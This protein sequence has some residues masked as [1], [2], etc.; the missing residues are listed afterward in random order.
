MESQFM[1]IIVEI[2]KL[3]QVIIPAIRI[4]DQQINSVTKLEIESRKPN[5][6]ETF[7]E[8]DLFDFFCQMIVLHKLTLTKCHFPLKCGAQYC[9]ENNF[10]KY[11]RPDCRRRP[12][13]AIRSKVFEKNW[14]NHCDLSL[15]KVAKS[16]NHCDL[17]LAKVAKRC[18]H[19]G[20]SLAK[21]AKRCYH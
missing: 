7:S 9:L 19:C 6:S 18:N 14:C 17:S 2:C 1:K 11:F 5:I 4:R 12:V 15:A 21:V 10:K 20:L 8:T 13:V 16:C 3:C